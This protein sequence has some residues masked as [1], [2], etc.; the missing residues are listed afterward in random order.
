MARAVA[1]VYDASPAG[2]VFG[3]VNAVAVAYLNFGAVEDWA[4]LAWL[5]F[6]IGAS[7]LRMLTV[8]MYRRSPAGADWHAPLRW[9]ACSSVVSG[10]AWG[11]AGVLLIAGDFGAGGDGLRATDLARQLVTLVFLIGMPAGAIFSFAPVPAVFYFYAV[12]MLLLPALVLAFNPGLA[13]GVFA[14]AIVTY[15]AFLTQ[16]GRRFGRLF[17]NSLEGQL[18]S[19]SLAAALAAENRRIDA[20]NRDLTLAHDEAERART[21]LEEEVARRTHALAEALERLRLIAENLPAYIVQVDGE[22]RVLYA[23]RTAAAWCGSAPAGVIGRAAADVLENPAMS[24]AGAET[25]AAQQEELIRYPDGRERWVHRVAVAAAAPDRAGRIVLAIDVSD[26]K[27]AEQELRR[28]EE[29]LLHARK[30]EA[31]GQLTGGVAHD[32]NNLLG[33]IVGNLELLEPALNG[34]SVARENLARAADAAGR[35]A[36]LTQRLLAFARKQILQPTVLDVGRLVADTVDLLARTLGE[37]V[38]VETAVADTLWPCLVDRSELET[39]IVNLAINARDAM[40]QGGCITIRAANADLSPAESIKLGLAPAQRY[41]RID[42]ADTGTGMPPDV[43]ERVFEPFFTT[44]EFG[45]GSGLGLSMVHGF[46]KQSGGAV[47]IATEIGRGTTVSLYLPQA[48]GATVPVP[49]Q[50]A[51]SPAIARGHG[52]VVLVVED[53]DVLR[54]IAVQVVSDL[55]YTAL[56]AADGPSALQILSQRNDIAVLFSDILLPNGLDGFAVARR[57]LEI[58]PAIKVVFA[59]GF[60]DGATAGKDAGAVRAPMLRKPYRKAELAEQIARALAQ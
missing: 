21:G 25:P 54:A 41:V 52:Q 27:R 48:S 53:N 13:S 37:T 36:T 10:L 30:L 50:P 20:M 24:A 17:K 57:A 14:G 6:T 35:A 26:R 42:V 31:I 39:A 32:F 55:G 40:P 4:L 19:E 44:K 22:G 11:I 5:A 3:V 2:A 1:A 16:A 12:P 59:S 8:V 28:R 58:L 15:L 51:K 34:S 45:K 38:R 9:A 56:Q 46:V 60:H 49:D 29:E 43:V 7:G 47:A 18:R 23:N 33:V